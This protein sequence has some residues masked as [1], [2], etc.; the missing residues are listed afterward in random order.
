MATIRHWLALYVSVVILFATTWAVTFKPITRSDALVNVTWPNRTRGALLECD[1]YHT[2]FNIM[3]AL[4]L[5]VRFLIIAM[6]NCCRPSQT[7]LHMFHLH[8]L[9]KLQLPRYP[10]F[11]PHNEVF[12]E[13]ILQVGVLM[14]ANS[15]R[16]DL[17]V[18]A[19]TPYLAG[20][21]S[22]RFSF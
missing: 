6:V 10:P 8:M 22:A 5:N 11:L 20:K 2:G 18:V 19:Q 9:E 1:W 15:G 12:D 4:G 14:L 21:F 17:S 7:P 3:S 16:I 13:T